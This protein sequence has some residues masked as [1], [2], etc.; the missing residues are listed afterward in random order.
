MK[1]NWFCAETEGQEENGTKGAKV[2]EGLET[3]P[4]C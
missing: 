1:S 2:A 4:T 3:L